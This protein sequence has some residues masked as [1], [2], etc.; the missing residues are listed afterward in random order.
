MRIIFT[1]EY[2]DSKDLIVIEPGDMGTLLNDERNL[3]MLDKDNEMVEY[4]DPSCFVLAEDES[5][6]EKFQQGE[7]L[8]S[9]AGEKV[10]EN[11]VF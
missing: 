8:K 11:F 9:S 7:I 5:E 6:I 1:K 2:I 3:I 4:I 10:G